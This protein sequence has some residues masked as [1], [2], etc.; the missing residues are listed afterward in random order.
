MW[1]KPFTIRSEN[2]GE[3]LSHIKEHY[4]HQGWA[5]QNMSCV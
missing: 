4:E 3:W 2:A 5:S 1:L